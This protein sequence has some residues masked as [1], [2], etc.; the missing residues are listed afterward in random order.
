MCHI[1]QFVLIFQ[2]S[3]RKKFWQKDILLAWRQNKKT[4]PK[5]PHHNP[6][7]ASTPG[8]WYSSDLNALLTTCV[9]TLW[10]LSISIKQQHPTTTTSLQKTPQQPKTTNPQTNTKIFSLLTPRVTTRFQWSLSFAVTYSLHKISF[11]VRWLCNPLFQS[12]LQLGGWLQIGKMCQGLYSDHQAKR[13]MKPALRQ[14]CPTCW[15]EASR[16]VL[17]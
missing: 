7:T 12:L 4:H 6:Q 8:K 14:I 13:L 11:F 10:G 1:N 9:S 3:A 17:L 2:S 15:G 16:S 5:K